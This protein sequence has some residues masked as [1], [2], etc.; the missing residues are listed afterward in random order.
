MKSKEKPLGVGGGN[1]FSCVLKKRHPASFADLFGGQL[2]VA[3]GHP[4][5]R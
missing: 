5:Q 2:Y 1:R 4:A 3:G